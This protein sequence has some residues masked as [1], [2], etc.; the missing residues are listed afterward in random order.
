MRALILGGTGAIGG[1]IARRF[2]E[3][4]YSVTCVGRSDFDLGN[5]DQI[6][7]FF[8]RMHENFDIL[9][10]SSAYN[11]PSPFE[12][13]KAEEIQ[14]SIQ[15]NLLGFLHVVRRCIPYWKLVKRGRIVVVSSLYGFLGRRARL[16]YVCSKHALNGAVKTLAIELG[17]SGVL[18]NSVSPGYFSTSLTQ[19]NNTQAEIEKLVLG[20]P[21]GR[22]GEPEEIARAVEFLCSDANTYIN[23]H[24]LV[25]DGGFSVGGFQ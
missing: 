23:G 25:V 8:N 12:S 21:L 16:P 11:F 10:H 13:L 14:R 3:V 9:V 18:V 4:G 15:T 20:I 24:D 22:L 6:D 5:S 17:G 2:F 19:K 1:A 7:A